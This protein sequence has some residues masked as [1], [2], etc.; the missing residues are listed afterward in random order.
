MNCWQDIRK[1][2]LMPDYDPE[3]WR[4]Y[5]GRGITM[6]EDWAASFGAFLADMSPTWAPG[7][8]LE[9]IDNNGPYS[10]NNCRWATPYEQARNRRTNVVIR[11]PG[12][13]TAI[14]TDVAR[15]IGM[16]PATLKHRIMHGQGPAINGRQLFQIVQNGMER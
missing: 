16:R 4:Q 1:R 7:L 11:M 8:T 5:G 14:L 9:R 2:C 12:G 3:K 15:D 10:R 6:A 13:A